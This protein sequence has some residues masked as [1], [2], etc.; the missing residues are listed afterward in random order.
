MYL[1]PKTNLLIAFLAAGILLKINFKW[2]G[3]GMLCLTSKTCKLSS[4][5]GMDALEIFKI[6]VSEL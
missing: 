5:I 6:S 3:K 2:E 4:K 1:C